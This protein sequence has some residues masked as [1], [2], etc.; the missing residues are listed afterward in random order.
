LRS[1]ADEAF[2]LPVEEAEEAEA[3]KAVDLMAALKASVEAARQARGGGK[4]GP[5]R[6]SGERR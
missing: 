5:R 1:K 2:A 3:P 6:S 4:G